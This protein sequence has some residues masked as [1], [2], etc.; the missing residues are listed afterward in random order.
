M[1][2]LYGRAKRGERCRAAIPHGHWKTTTFVG[3]LRRT[4]LT[5]PMVLDGPMHGAAFLAYVEQV[6]V[7][8]LNPGDVVVMD[9]LP[10]HKPVAVREAIHKAGAT[11]R[12]LPPY[13]PDFN[14]IENAFAKFKALLKK[15]AARTIDELWS[16]I[17]ETI[18]EFTPIE[19]ENYFNA[20]GYDPI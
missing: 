6:L 12:F 17:G 10:A 15:A 2:R 8:T 18:T 11:L 3:A 13:S 14:P 20:A 19:C 7:P 5:A 16:A 1:A 9:N 4:G